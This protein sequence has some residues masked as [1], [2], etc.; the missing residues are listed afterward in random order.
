M[1]TIDLVAPVVPAMTAQRLQCFKT[2]RCRFWLENRCSRGDKCTYAHT[3]VELRCPPDLTK[4]KICTRWKRGACEKLPSECAYAHGVEDLRGG[5]DETQAVET[6]PQSVSSPRSTSQSGR[7]SSTTYAESTP[8]KSVGLPIG[9]ESVDETMTLSTSSGTSLS[10]TDSV[11]G[12]KTASY[13]FRHGPSSTATTVPACSS[14]SSS[15]ASCTSSTSSS[16]GIRTIIG[17]KV[18]GMRLEQANASSTTTSPPRHESAARPAGGVTNSNPEA[19]RVP[20]LPL[21]EQSIPSRGQTYAYSGNKQGNEYSLDFTTP[22]VG[23]ESKDTVRSV[24]SLASTTFPPLTPAGTQRSMGSTCDGFALT[25]YDFPRHPSAKKQHLYDVISSDLEYCGDTEE[26]RER[27][28]C[29]HPCDDVD[30]TDVY[31]TFSI[32]QEK[33]GAINFMA[34]HHQPFWTSNFYYEEAEEVST[35]TLCLISALASP[36]YD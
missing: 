11:I 14:S 32:A 19:L 35:M 4:T 17:S 27:P 3:D 23:D 9:A 20:R 22:K 24:E 28:F 18:C 12:T 26:E 6:P 7:T 34:P 16:S 10:S 21:A 30:S 29:P 2:K 8:D 13:E 36:Y 5:G 1:R 15:V 25:G 31:S 33:Y